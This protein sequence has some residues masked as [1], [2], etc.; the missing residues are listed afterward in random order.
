M[1]EEVLDD[2]C[3]GLIQA[4]EGVRKALTGE[5]PSGIGGESSWT[6][7]NNAGI[8]GRKW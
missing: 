8:E 3:F 6:I 7:R 2:L 1:V 4:E 5:I